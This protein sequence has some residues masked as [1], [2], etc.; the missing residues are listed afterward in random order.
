MRLGFGLAVLTALAAG[1]VRLGYEDLSV[2]SGG[3]VADGGLHGT[4]D[5]HSSEPRDGNGSGADAARPSD[6]PSRPDT[7]VTDQRA[8][9]AD[10]GG[11]LDSG[12][13]PD[14]GLKVVSPPRT[15]G[16]TGVT[17]TYDAEAN[18]EG[19]L[20]W[21]L[22]E[23]PEGMS[24]DGGTGLLRWA[25]PTEGTHAVRLRATL[26]D[27]AP[28][29][30]AFSL[31]VISCGFGLCNGLRPRELHDSRLGRDLR[32]LRSLSAGGL[33]DRL[34]EPAVREVLGQPAS[35]RLLSY[36]IGC[37]LR[38]DQA[39][40]ASAG[41]GRVV[42]L[43]G[44]VGLAAEWQWMACDRR[45]RERVSACV[46]ARLNP[47]GLAVPVALAWRDAPEPLEGASHEEG[48]YFG[49]LFREHPVALACRGRDG[50]STRHPSRSCLGHP[51]RCALT[52]VGRC[53]EV[54]Q[55]GPGAYRRCSAGG[56]TYAEPLT[57]F[58]RP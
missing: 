25:A 33:G 24:I 27:S 36:V 48:A 22:V 32:L 8:Q 56:V 49:D 29:E 57:V 37:A 51:K 9:L 26:G 5:A 46:L 47:A 19:A 34:R 58:L 54:C 21:Q 17:Y 4:R 31:R 1:C 35:R 30:Q 28:A 14:I 50:P 45:C 13:A 23:A 12:V 40:S 53:G 2:P 6:A 10:A 11:A 7:V 43:T 20:S 55:A 15:T 39:L 44:G 41:P 3:N 16:V 38:R 18:V 52:V 42:T